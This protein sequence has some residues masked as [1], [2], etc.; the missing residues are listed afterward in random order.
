ME[1]SQAHPALV[2]GIQTSVLAVDTEVA[3]ELDPAMVQ[4]PLEVNPPDCSNPFQPESTVLLAQGPN[5]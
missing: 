4:E 5:K 2:K 3:Y 1:R